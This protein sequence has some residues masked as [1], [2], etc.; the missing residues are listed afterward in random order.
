MI[1]KPNGELVISLEFNEQLNLTLLSDES[2]KNVH[3]A[4]RFGTCREAGQVVEHA[5]M[6][7]NRNNDLREAVPMPD[8]KKPVMIRV[9]VL[10]E[11]GN[12]TQIQT[13]NMED[14]RSAPQQGGTLTTAQIARARVLWDRI[15]HTARP[16]ID[17][18]AWFDGFARERY[19]ERELWA[20]EAIALMV[21][22]LW[23]DSRF[24]KNLT[25]ESL[26]KAVIGITINIVDIP[27]QCCGVTDEHVAV[28]RRMLAEAISDQD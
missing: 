28:V 7:S 16:N 26:V 8:R 5:T 20:W 18:N 1:R 2:N 25:K 24:S 9:Q 17:R 12:P 14:V 13:V 22:E 4:T 6:A 3:I 10:D 19:P 23:E 11:Y 15:G 21:E 27:S